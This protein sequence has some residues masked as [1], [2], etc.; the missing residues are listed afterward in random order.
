[1]RAALD[2]PDV[3]RVVVVV[4][5]GEEDD[6]AAALADHLGEREVLL[7]VGGTTRHDSEWAALRV[8]RADVERGAVDVVAVHD[9]ARPLARPGL[10]TAVIEAAR[11]EGGAIPVV[12][13]SALLGPDGPVRDAVTVQTPQAFRAADAIAA[14]ER[15]DAEGFAATDTAGVLARYGSGR[16]VA[17]PSSV[18]NLKVTWPGDLALAERLRERLEQ[19]DVVGAVDPVGG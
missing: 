2:T 18:T 9:A 6:V 5:P 17:V 14:H 3:V 1:V 13:A 15:A 11:A 10:F 16:V 12:P 7:V 19:A 8:L 4:R